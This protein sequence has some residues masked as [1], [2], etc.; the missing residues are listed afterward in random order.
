MAE[1]SQPLELAQALRDEAKSLERRARLLK[2]MAAKLVDSLQ[3]EED[4]S[5]RA[6][7]ASAEHSD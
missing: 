5:G 6:E 3:S 1:S 4:T 7:A 2:Q